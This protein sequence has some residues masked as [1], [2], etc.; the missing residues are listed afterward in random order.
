MSQKLRHLRIVLLATAFAA[1][2][3]PFSP[4]MAQSGDM[5]CDGA[6]DIADIPLFVE[7]MLPAGGFGGCD[8]N[9][10]DMNTDTLIDGRD[11]QAFVAALLAP[12]CP[13][14]QTLCFGVCHD[15]RN[16][17]SFCG[18]TCENAVSCSVFETCTDGVC[19]PVEP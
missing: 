8:I 3:S 7:A 11:T 19:V 1:G 5:N 17:I 6:F 12:P 13:G 10:A 4:A 18:T 14:G 9:R 15:L 2:W 16:E